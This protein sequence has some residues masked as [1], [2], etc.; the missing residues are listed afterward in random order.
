[1]TTQQLFAFAIIAALV[2]AGILTHTVQLH[3]ATQRILAAM[4]QQIG[5]VR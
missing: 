1:M 3:Y 5:S 4:P 2:L